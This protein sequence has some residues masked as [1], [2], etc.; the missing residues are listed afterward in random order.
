M[1]E[2]DTN[3]N[4]VW[5]CLDCLLARG[6]PPQ[7]CTMEAHQVAYITITCRTIAACASQADS[8][9]WP[10]CV[11]RQLTLAVTASRTRFGQG[12]K[13]VC[14]CKSLVQNDRVTTD[15]LQFAQKSTCTGEVGAQQPMGNVA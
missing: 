6:T 8:T 12:C 11:R 1:N 10:T 4:G 7:L 5:Q 13:V 9:A 15:H 3:C 14:V 2:L